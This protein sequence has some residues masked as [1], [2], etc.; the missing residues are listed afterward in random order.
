MRIIPIRGTNIGTGTAPVHAPGGVPVE[1]PDAL[2]RELLALGLASRAP[3]P[4]PNTG[5]PDFTGGAVSPAEH[6]TVTD[7]P[8]AT[9]P[10]RES[11]AVAPA[12]ETAAATPAPKKRRA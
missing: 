1:C 10:A 11:A 8:G 9:R 6:S 2:A 4:A 12:A 3:S 7:Q 5:D